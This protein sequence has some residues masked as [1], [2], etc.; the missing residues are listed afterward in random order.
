MKE[1][2]LNIIYHYGIDKQL[3]YIHTEYFELDEAIL[4]YQNAGWDFSDESCEDIE[5]EY[6]HHIA[7][8]LA[9]I[10]VMLEQFREYFGIEPEQVFDMMKYKIQRQLDRIDKENK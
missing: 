4:D 1:D 6:K 2:L 5:R 9:D 3:K 7:E 10:Q 8:E